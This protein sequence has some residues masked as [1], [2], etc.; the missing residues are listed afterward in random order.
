MKEFV[1]WAWDE[2]IFLQGI[3]FPH[4]KS[5]Q[6]IAKDELGGLCVGISTCRKDFLY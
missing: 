5:N 2:V 1:D 4:P 6:W 3:P